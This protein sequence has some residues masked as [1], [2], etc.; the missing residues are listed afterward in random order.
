MKN[1]SRVIVVHGDAH[2]W[3]EEA[4]FIL[5]GDSPPPKDF[6][7]EA[8]RI[9]NAYL[10]G[11]SG[12]ASATPLRRETV[13]VPSYTHVPV[14]AKKSNVDL[15]LNVLTFICCVILTVLMAMTFL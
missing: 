1:D 6:V 15:T 3:F 8:E 9:V 13:K 4:V 14:A 2:K 11:K 10:S 12:A 5:K 7:K